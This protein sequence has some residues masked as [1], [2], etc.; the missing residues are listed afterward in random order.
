MGARCT[1]NSK[2]TAAVMLGIAAGFAVLIGVFVLVGDGKDTGNAVPFLVIMMGSAVAIGAS[3]GRGGCCC[4]RK[5]FGRTKTAEATADAGS[6]PNPYA[7][8]RVS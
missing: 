2:A 1:N 7:P 4:F 5:L 8:D 3:S 6:E